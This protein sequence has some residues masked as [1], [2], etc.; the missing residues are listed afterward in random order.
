MISTVSSQEV[1]D[2]IFSV[3][4]NKS[5]GL[6]GYTGA[7]F[8]EAWD[9]IVHDV[10]KAVQE[11]FVNGSLLKELNHTIIALIPKMKDSLATLISS[12]QYAFVLGRRI[13]DNILLTQELMHNYHLE[14]GP[15]RC[16]FKVDIQKAYDIVDWGVL[17][18]LLMGLGFI[19]TRSEFHSSLSFV[20]GF[21][22]SGGCGA[23]MLRWG[24]GVKQVG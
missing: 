18:E 5:S 21:G 17:H 16:A 6:D 22:L 19:L 1:C 14:K 9:I 3:G 15:P 11:F 2:V 13:T 12:I 24:K 4:N 8:K 10:I 7:F 23:E 20:V